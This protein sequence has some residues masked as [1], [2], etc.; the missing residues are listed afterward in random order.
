MLRPV[1]SHPRAMVRPPVPQ[2]WATAHQPQLSNRLGQPKPNFVFSGGL[3]PPLA[4]HNEL[5]NRIGNQS[6]SQ[7]CMSRSN[8]ITSN[9]HQTV[10]LNCLSSEYD[11]FHA[12]T[13][14]HGAQQMKETELETQISVPANQETK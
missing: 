2:P 9:R 3:R 10:A 7:N 6:V 14:L 5:N 12:V 11:L 1:I 4:Y 8:K 13:R